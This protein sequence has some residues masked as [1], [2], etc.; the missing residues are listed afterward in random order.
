[1]AVID[2]V[3]LPDN[4][5]Y[6]VADN[7]SGYAKKVAGATTDD[8]ASLTAAG[9]LAD[10]GKKLSDLVLK[11]DV[12]DVLNSTSTTDPLSANQGRVL[13]ENIEA[14]VDIY[15]A[16]QMLPYPFYDTTKT[17]NG[18]TFTDNGNGTLTING[19]ASADAVFILYNAGSDYASRFASKTIL[20]NI[21]GG[22]AKTY[23]AGQADNQFFFYTNDEAQATFPLN[24][25]SYL[26]IYII[27]ENGAV[28]TTPITISFMIRDARI[29]DPTVVPYAS[30]NR[31]LMS[32]KAN[33]KV[34]SHN[35][36]SYPYRDTTTTMNGVTFTDIGDGRVKV[37]SSSA[38]TATA[39]TSF[40]LHRYTEFQLYLQN[41]TYILSGCPSGGALESKYQLLLAYKN[42]SNVEVYAFDIGNEATFTIDGSYGDSEGA[43]VAMGIVISN[44]YTV[45]AGGIMFKPMIRIAEDTDPNYQP[46][47]MTNRQLTEEI[48]AI[49]YKK[50]N[51]N[52]ASTDFEAQ[53]GGL[54]A[55]KNIATDVGGSV[56]FDGCFV[57]QIDGVYSSCCCAI[58]GIDSSTT[59]L[60]AKTFDTSAPNVTIT[61][62]YH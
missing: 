3:K 25:N 36:N 42:P 20:A 58:R 44:G 57:S 48:K 34:G 47:A 6:D 14:L 8:L 54:V 18:I 10:S 49:K 16:K 11:A 60:V 32:Y 46:F 1:M 59:Y 7:Y 35:L 28:I 13:A 29:T 39:G 22:N 55:Y 51:I 50:V 52:F 12:K 43:Y 15:G 38:Q 56:N 40:R 62:L 2:S 4:S 33:G 61:V 9:D 45:P 24:Y 41:G 53:S 23:F 31:E 37:G 19:T 27:V 5:T 26:G 17:E 30:T 21:S